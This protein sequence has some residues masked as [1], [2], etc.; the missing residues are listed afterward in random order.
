MDGRWWLGEPETAKRRRS[1]EVA[2][3]TIEMLRA[4]RARQAER[5]LANRHRMTDDD[6]VFCDPAGEPLWGRLLTALSLK[7]ILRRR[8]GPRGWYRTGAH[9]RAVR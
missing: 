2:D 5:L 4:H 8:Y 9:C 7:P 3:P 1:I 6:L